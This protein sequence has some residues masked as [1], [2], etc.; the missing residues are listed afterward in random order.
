MGRYSNLLNYVVSPGR[1]V[2]AAIRADAPFERRLTWDAHPYPQY[3]YG[4]AHAARQAKRLGIPRMST[5]EFGVAGGNG[6]VQ[7]EKHARDVT[8]ITGVE[9]VVYGMDSGGGLPPAQGNRDLPYIF[10]AG[11]FRM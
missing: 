2:Q 8:A 10:R 5:V 3:A 4:L 9:V 1:L 6:L 11:Q 7:M